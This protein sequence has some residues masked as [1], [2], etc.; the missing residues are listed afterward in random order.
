MNVAHKFTSEVSRPGAGGN[1]FTASP[2]I[3]IIAIS[4]TLALLATAELLAAGEQE[5]QEFIFLGY[6][7]PIIIGSRYFSRRVA[8]ITA[9]V[10]TVVYALAFIPNMISLGEELDELSIELAGRFLMFMVTGFAL[11][12]FRTS[13]LKEQER[14]VR[15]EHQRAERLRLMLEISRTITSSLKIDQVLQV[16]A[17]RVAETVDATFCR[18]ALLDESGEYLRM[19]AAHPVRQLEAEP[20]IGMSIAVADLTEFEKALESRTAVII[21]GRR[22]ED[23][24]KLPPHEREFMSDAKSLML[25]PLVVG[26]KAVGV[27]CIGEQRGWD[28]S[29]LSAEKAALCQTIVNQGAVAVGH[30]LSH[31]ALEEA[32]VGTIRSLA[33]AIDAKDPSTRGHSDW[34]S[35]YALMIGRQMGMQNHHLDELKY[36][37]YLHDVGK[38]GIPDDILGKTSQ[39]STEEW[40]L[41]KKHPIVSARILDPVPISAT[42]K[43][44]IRHHHERYDGKGYPYGLAGES[45]PLEARIL[46][47]ADS[48]EAMTADRPYRKALSDE[49]AVAEMLRCSGTQF[50]PAIVQA[51]LI[52]LGRAPSAAAADIESVAS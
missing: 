52:A 25:Y 10:A 49:Q 15:A 11:G 38:I 48:F 5:A 34:V 23:I 8:I 43:G 50:D 36:A 14:S 46:S 32:F 17:A 16:L 35:K 7:A 33:E 37:G 12:S 2:K 42:I 18:V 41:M 45:I 47:V 4:V 40:K 30:A 27:V 31:Q 24:E 1:S 3:P 19:V 44:A 20:Y 26:E 28:R 51:F 6:F 9:A 21:G 39:L 29:P 13:F 22:Q